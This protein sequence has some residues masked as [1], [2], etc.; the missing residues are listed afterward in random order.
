MASNPNPEVGEFP[1]PSEDG[2]RSIIEEAVKLRMVPYHGQV[3]FEYRFSGR[4]PEVV[5]E[6][7][8]IY[9]ELLF[10]KNVDAIEILGWCKLGTF[11][12]EGKARV[13]I[14][15]KKFFQR[16]TFQPRTRPFCNDKKTQNEWLEQAKHCLRCDELRKSVRDESDLEKRYPYFVFGMTLW[17]VGPW[18]SGNDRDDFLHHLGYAA[19]EY[20]KSMGLFNNY[21]SPF[22]QSIDLGRATE[23]KESQ[24]R[25]RFL[26]GVVERGLLCIEYPLYRNLALFLRI[27]PN[28]FKRSVWRLAHACYSGMDWNH[29]LKRPLFKDVTQTFG[30]DQLPLI[31]GSKGFVKEAGQNLRDAYIEAFE[32]SPSELQRVCEERQLQSYVRY[33][34]EDIKGG[35]LHPGALDALQLVDERN[36]ILPPG[37]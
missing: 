4:K 8:E 2:Y 25:D 14:Q 35:V 17:S 19:A 31:T 37:L 22:K 23:A 11:T 36:G 30:F 32:I 34:W 7:L 15:H 16:T 9:H 3:W 24:D 20:S 10:V 1:V 27:A 6:L 28:N 13:G 5:A 26:Q 29:M 33:V 12:E 21:A 18:L